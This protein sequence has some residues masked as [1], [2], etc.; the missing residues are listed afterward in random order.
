[1]VLPGGKYFWTYK[2]QPFRHV[3]PCHTVSHGRRTPHC[4]CLCC[5]RVRPCSS[6]PRALLRDVDGLML[7]CV[8]HCVLCVL[9]ET[10]C[11]H[12][13]IGMNRPKKT[14]VFVPELLKV[15]ILLR[16]HA[17]EQCP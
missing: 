17:V 8:C 11:R 2:R 15:N 6:T 12:K 7:T 10:M 3:T 13:G 1:M 5:A 16:G 14:K 9:Q 4:S